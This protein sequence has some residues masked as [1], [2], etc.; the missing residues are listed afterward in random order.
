MK[1]SAEMFSQCPTGEGAV[2]LSTSSI[3]LAADFRAASGIDSRAPHF[4]SV[5]FT[6][7]AEKTGHPMWSPRSGEFMR[8]S[9]DLRSFYMMVQDIP[10]QTASVTIKGGDM[11]YMRQLQTMRGF[12]PYRRAKGGQIPGGCIVGAARTEYEA[13]L[14]LHE[15]SMEHFGELA[16]TA[17]PLR[18]N[19]VTKV[20][21]STGELVGIR[22]Y[23]NSEAYTGNIG[24]RNRKELGLQNGEGLGDMLFD[25]FSLV[26]CEYIYALPE[27]SNVRVNDLYSYLLFGKLDETPDT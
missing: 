7:S 10:G 5:I 14:Y 22:D 25:R 11:P 6:P 23:A 16:S 27:P 12:A 3:A 21:S 9:N 19:E 20:P 26:P 24:P 2:L 13:G 1:T 18:L 4:D 17:Y 8:S 15:R